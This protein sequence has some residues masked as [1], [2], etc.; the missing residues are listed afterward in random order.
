M[1]VDVGSPFGSPVSLASLTFNNTN[2]SLKL[3]TARAQVAREQSAHGARLG[4]WS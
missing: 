4:R 1:P 2:D 3:A